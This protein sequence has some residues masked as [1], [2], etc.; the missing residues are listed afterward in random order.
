MR[1]LRLAGA[2]GPAP[3]G[4][5]PNL[6]GRGLMQPKESPVSEVTPG[7]WAQSHVAVAQVRCALV[8][9]AARTQTCRF[10]LVAAS[11]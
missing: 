5:P 1:R 7:R 4:L 6:E 9:A 3:P 2:R 8:D 10:K 11:Q